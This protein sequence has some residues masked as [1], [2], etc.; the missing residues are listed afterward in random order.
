MWFL[1]SP[2]S[3]RYMLHNSG[4]PVSALKGRSTGESG[5]KRPPGRVGHLWPILHYSGHLWPRAAYQSEYR[6][7][8]IGDSPLPPLVA[9]ALQQRIVAALHRLLHPAVDRIRLR[10]GDRIGADCARKL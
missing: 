1:T 6:R 10:L 5:R 8:K 3:H 7:V 4:E 9:V 2:R